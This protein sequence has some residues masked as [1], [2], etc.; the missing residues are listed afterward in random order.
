MSFDTRTSMLKFVGLES[1]EEAFASGSTIGYFRANL[2]DIEFF[3]KLNSSKKMLIKNGCGAYEMLSRWLY[4]EGI[5]THDGK[6]LS[7]KFIN[8]LLAKARANPSGHRKNTPKVELVK[9]SATSVKGEAVV[10]PVEAVKAVPAGFRDCV[11]KSFDQL[12]AEGWDQDKAEAV[13]VKTY[14]EWRMSKASVGWTQE[15][16]DAMNFFWFEVCNADPKFLVENNY[17]EVVE[18]VKFID[19]HRMLENLKWK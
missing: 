3:V 11:K 17:Y 8:H 19:I 10:V 5:T 14:Q 6:P 16:E 9:P 13:L 15:T 7:T 12:K 18:G 4:G 1:E 2:A